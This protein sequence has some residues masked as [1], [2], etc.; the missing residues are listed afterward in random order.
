LPAE[1]EPIHVGQSDIE[2]DRRRPVLP[3][4]GQP[5]PAGSA[6]EHPEAGRHQVSANHVGDDRFVF[7]QQHQAA[8]DTGGGRLRLGPNSVRTAEG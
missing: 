6:D 2:H 7:D 1:V 5:V 8:S 4:R 3:D